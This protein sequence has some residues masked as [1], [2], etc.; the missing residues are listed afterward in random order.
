QRVAGVVLAGGKMK[1]EMAALAGGTNRALIEVGGRTM[2]DS[3]IAAIVGSDR[4]E[5]IIVAGDV[6]ESGQYTRI[7]DTGGFVENV[8]AGAAAAR[9]SNY[10][11]LV[12]ADLPFLS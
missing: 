4:I 10:V 2:L 1:P 6:P 8:F 11:L 9:D 3:V 5:R 12:T 7:P